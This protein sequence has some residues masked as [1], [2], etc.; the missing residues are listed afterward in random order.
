[1]LSQH[2]NSL[3]LTTTED[4]LAAIA[5][6]E[7][8]LTLR[9]LEHFLSLTDYLCSSIYC[10]AQIAT[11]LQDLKTLFLKPA[12]IADGQQKAFA[13][14]IKLPTPTDAKLTSFQMLKDVL[15]QTITLV[16]YLPDHVLWINLDALKEFGF[17]VI[18]FHINNEKAV[19][20]GKWPPKMS[21]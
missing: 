11:P 6:I 21:I 20:A 18:M 10:Y 14:K 3:G 16:Y 4:K 7:Y 15:L 2:V 8:P 5:A 19:L 12:L 1:M 17:G 13:L 9:D